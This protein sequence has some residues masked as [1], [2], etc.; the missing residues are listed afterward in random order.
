M[1]E[2]LA[3]IVAE[4]HRTEADLVEADLVDPDLVDPEVVDL[5]VSEV[6]ETDGEVVESSDQ[7]GQNNLAEEDHMAFP[8]SLEL[9]EMH[10]VVDRSRDC[11]EDSN[12]E[13][14]MV[15]DVEHAVESL[16]VEME[17]GYRVQGL[18]V[19]AESVEMRSIALESAKLLFVG[20]CDH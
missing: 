4:D 14:V 7:E 15:V 2:N 1:L 18:A 6:E 10:L 3:V 13:I 17:A 16:V 19:M 12:S 5:S 11:I 8:E 9:A 20:V